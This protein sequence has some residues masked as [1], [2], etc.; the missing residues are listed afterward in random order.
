MHRFAVLVGADDLDEVVLRNRVTGL[1][2]ED[3][4][5][6]GLGAA[7]IV[8]A[9]EVSHRVGDT[10]AGISV[11]M[12]ISLIA[13]RDCHGQPIPF[14][15]AFIDAVHVL[16]EWQLEVQTGFGSWFAHR[17]AEL[18]ND[19]LFGLMD[20]VEAA[21]NGAENNQDPKDRK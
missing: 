15:K 7:L 2:A 17:F 5:E 3:V 11:D 20:R 6:T 21:E 16:N 14:E 18:S 19:N 8:Q 12:D 4:L 9:H 13:G 10:P 1:A